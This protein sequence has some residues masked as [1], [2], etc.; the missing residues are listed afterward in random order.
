MAPSTTPI[1]TAD[2][3]GW[4][5][6]FLRANGIRFHYVTQGEGP[7]VLLLHGFPECWYSWR[8]QIPVLAATHKVVALDLRGYNDT[9]KPTE[10]AAYQMDVLVADVV[11]VVQ[12][13]GYERLTL[14]GHD[15]GGAIAWNTADRHPELLDNLVVLNLPHPARMLAGLRTPQQLLKSWYIFFFQ[16]PWLPEIALQLADYRAI[17]LA[18]AGMAIDKATFSKAD[19]DFFKDAAAKRGAVPAMLNY[20]RTIFSSGQL[21]RQWRVLEM[22]TLMIWGEND[23]ALGKELTYGTEQYVRDLQIKYIPNCSHWVQ[24]ER[25]DLV[26]QYLCD[27]LAE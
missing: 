16:L 21:N 17:E 19:L 18:L 25:P 24:Q 13:L 23:A 27:F 10:P 1:L 15:W 12:A 11:A 14:V 2:R 8:H 3:A 4:Q 22:P 5:H 7:L 9:D 6:G 20:Y 26:N